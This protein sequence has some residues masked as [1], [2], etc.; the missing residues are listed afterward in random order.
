MLKDTNIDNNDKKSGKALVTPLYG[1][2]WL[3][4]RLERWGL[5]LLT[6]IGFAFLV[7]VILGWFIPALYNVLK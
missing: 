3:G 7:P 2:F 6:S 5:T 1:I 4:A